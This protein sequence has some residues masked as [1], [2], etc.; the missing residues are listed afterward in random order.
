MKS[1]FL[2]RL[3]TSILILISSFHV[4][5][6]QS[7]TKLMIDENDYFSLQSVPIYEGIDE[8]HAKIDKIR[9]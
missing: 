5:T 4:L 2:K 8:F 1:V 7:G 3:L 9:K 6:A